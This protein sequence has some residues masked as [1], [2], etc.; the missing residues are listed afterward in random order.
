MDKFFI[1]VVLCLSLT[2]PGVGQSVFD[3]S[4]AKMCWSVNGTDSSLLRYTVISVRVPSVPQRITYRNAEGENV[5][6]SGGDLAYGFCEC[7]S[8][9]SIPRFE[10]F[11][12]VAPTPNPF[13]PST[14]NVC[15]RGI[16]CYIYGVTDPNTE[17]TVTTDGNPLAFSFNPTT[18]YFEC[19]TPD[20]GSGSG[21]H[22]LI[23]TVTTPQGTIQEVVNFDCGT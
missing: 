1:L 21:T 12:V 2:V 20:Y 7:C 14:F 19:Q 16:R 11:N 5:T 8:R 4:P 13:D 3:I 15:Y 23:L 22:D 18:N 10:D 9:D 6:V 17:I